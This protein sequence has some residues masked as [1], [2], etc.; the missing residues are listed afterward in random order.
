MTKW[1]LD[2]IGSIKRKVLT[3]E[4]RP[5]EKPQKII[6]IVV[7]IINKPTMVEETLDKEQLEI[8][9]LII[10]YSDKIEK[11]TLYDKAINN[12]IYSQC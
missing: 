2:E 6:S 1:F 8:A 12:L 7:I 5:R 4:L 11:T 9:I 10:K 3:E